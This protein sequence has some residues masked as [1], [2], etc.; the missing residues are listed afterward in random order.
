MR[1]R[2]QDG[3]FTDVLNAHMDREQPLETRFAYDN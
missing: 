2:G 1:T 3:W